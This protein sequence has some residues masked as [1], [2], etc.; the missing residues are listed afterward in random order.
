MRGE[1]LGVRNGAGYGEGSRPGC[2]EVEAARYPVDVEHFA[3]KVE[4]GDV[5][6]L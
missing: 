1:R 3:G 6:A 4:M 2:L 5:A